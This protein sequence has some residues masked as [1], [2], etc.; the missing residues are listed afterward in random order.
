MPSQGYIMKYFKNIL[1]TITLAFVFNGCGVMAT[2]V[3]TPNTDKMNDYNVSSTNQALLKPLSKHAYKV[4]VG[5]FIDTTD[6]NNTLKCRIMNAVTP[7][8]DKTYASYMQE[9]FIKELSASNLYSRKSDISIYAKIHEIYGSTTYGD[10]Y[11]SFDITLISSNQESYHLI[12][13]YEYPSSLSAAYACTEMCETFP[14]ALQKLI[15]DA[16]KD[17]KFK[18]LLQKSK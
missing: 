15:H 14:L 13:K 4:N 17:P 7:P 8:K 1:L 2:L 12:S 10:A 5:E 11:W 16:I 3:M 18:K 6:T 9:A